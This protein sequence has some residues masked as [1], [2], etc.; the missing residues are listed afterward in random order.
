MKKTTLSILA[1]AS[2]LT[3]GMA[4]CSG[5]SNTE[6]ENVETVDTLNAESVSVDYLLDNADSLVGKTVNVEAVCTHIC[7]RGGRKIFLMGSDDTRTIRVEAGELG[8]FDKKCAR[9]IVNVT[10]TLMEERIDEAYLKDWEAKAAAA[11]DQHGD[12][13]KGGC[14]AEKNARGESGESVQ[15]RIDAFR[16]KIAERK[17]A[18]GR[19]YLSFY[20][21]QAISYSVNDGE[22]N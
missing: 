10:G 9:S 19:D 12:V 11:Q 1:I 16:Q 5:S 15:D 13:K 21:I 20:Y 22:R 3:A 14:D 2:I 8:A 17:A 4:S 18:D 7:S 6:K